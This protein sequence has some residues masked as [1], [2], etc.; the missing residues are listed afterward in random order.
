MRSIPELR[1]RGRR[2]RG[3]GG[4]GRGVFGE[5]EVGEGNENERSGFGD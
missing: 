1:E 3:G 2:L 4:V 5:L